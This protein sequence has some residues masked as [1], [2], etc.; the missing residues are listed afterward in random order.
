VGDIVE[1]GV[2]VTV[3]GNPNPA[4]T[5]TTG[6]ATYNFANQDQPANLGL[7]SYGFGMND[8]KPAVA[9]VVDASA[10]GGTTTSLKGAAAAAWD[11][12]RPGT[13]D[14]VGGGISGSKP[15][16][17]GVS[18]GNHI[19][20]G[21]PAANQGFFGV[22]ASGAAELLNELEIQTGVAGTAV[23]TPTDQVGPGLLGL[24]EYLSG[25]TTISSVPLYTNH[26][27]TDGDGNTVNNLPPLTVVVGIPEPASAGML[28]AVASG[29][30]LRRRKPNA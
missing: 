21:T 27:V 18:V 10:P 15:E 20:N 14:D 25:G 23:F 19:A 12:F 24:V 17:G 30:M 7:A 9:S 1:F 2:D 28:F 5:G 4:A 29:L 13:V 3:T 6:S 11:T 16:S 26:T 22:G 8:T